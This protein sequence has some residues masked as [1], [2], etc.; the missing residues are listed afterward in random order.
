LN[1]FA[2]SLISVLAVASSAFLT[3]WRPELFTWS[4]TIPATLVYF[5]AFAT[6][7]SV[8][9]VVPKRR[10]PW[11]GA[12]VAEASRPKASGMPSWVAE[13]LFYLAFSVVGVIAGMIAGTTWWVAGGYDVRS[14][15]E[16]LKIGAIL[17]GAVILLLF[18]A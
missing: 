5:G 10:L 1:A 2:I 15:A 16:A 3:Y 17:G 9:R 7:F 4:A 6:I 18:G 8:L 12:G 14:L 11:S 13:L